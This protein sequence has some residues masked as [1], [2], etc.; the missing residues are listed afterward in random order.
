MTDH[1]PPRPLRVL[2]RIVAGIGWTILGTLAYF[3]CQGAFGG[4]P[5]IHSALL[6]A[7]GMIAIALIGGIAWLVDERRPHDD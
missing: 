5:K 6:T 4:Y 1:T 2:L 3:I 7:F